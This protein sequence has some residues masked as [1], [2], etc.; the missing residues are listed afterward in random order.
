VARGS[1]RIVLVGRGFSRDI[2]TGTNSKKS[3][4]VPRA[5]QDIERVRQ[6]FRYGFQRLD[7]AFWASRQIYD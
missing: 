5:A 6:Q 3:L 7:R 2:Q 4:V 1:S